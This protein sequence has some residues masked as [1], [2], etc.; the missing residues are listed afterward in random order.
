MTDEELYGDNDPVTPEPDPVEVD[1]IA[2]PAPPVYPVDSPEAKF[3]AIALDKRWE[4]SFVYAGSAAQLVREACDEVAPGGRGMP[5]LLADGSYLEGDHK[6]VLQAGFPKFC[7]KSVKTLK[8]AISGK[9]DRPFHDGTY[10]VKKNP[11]PVDLEAMDQE[12]Q[13]AP[14][15]YRLEEAV[16]DCYWERTSKSGDIIANQF[17]TSAQSITVTIRASDGQF[18]AQGCG[19][20]WPVR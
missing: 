15:T 18:T 14:G 19:A 17:A 20:W 1:G 11:K 5:A 13:V 8:K 3:D 9:F 10:I 12:E 16:E 2:E 6:A 4:V 7:P